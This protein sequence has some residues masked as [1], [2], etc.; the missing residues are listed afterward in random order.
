MH[1]MDLFCLLS[2]A[3]TINLTVLQKLLQHSSCIIPLELGV[4]QCSIQTGT[5]YFLLVPKAGLKSSQ[6]LHLKMEL[7][8][9]WQ[10]KFPTIAIH[11]KTVVLLIWFNIVLIIFP[12]Y[13]VNNMNLITIST[14]FLLLESGHK[15]SMLLFSFHVCPVTLH[16]MLHTWCHSFHPP[17]GVNYFDSHKV[18]T[19]VTLSCYITVA[20]SCYLF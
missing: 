20:T 1:T 3:T 14:I 18:G 9:V 16:I 6:L 15:N 8:C 11:L 17:I 4:E 5:A 12:N 13:I 7:T 2:P 10:L 19:L